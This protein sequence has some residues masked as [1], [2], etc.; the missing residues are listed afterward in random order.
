MLTIADAEDSFLSGQ[1]DWQEFREQ[2][3][4]SWY[5]P[6]GQSLLAALVGAMPEDMRARLEELRNGVT[7]T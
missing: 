2:F 7:P 1:M 5:G 3:E 6:L 4:R